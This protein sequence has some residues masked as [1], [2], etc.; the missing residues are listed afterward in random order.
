M[1]KNYKINEYG[2]TGPSTPKVFVVKEDGTYRET[3]IKLLSRIPNLTYDMGGG[4]TNYYPEKNIVIVDNIPV[5]EFAADPGDI[6]GGKVY[7]EYNLNIPISLPKANKIIV[8]QV[9]YH[10]DNVKNFS[11][12]LNNSLNKGG[13][14]NFWT[15]LEDAEED[16]LFLQYM[17]EYGF[18]ASNEEDRG[19]ENIILKK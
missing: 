8:S 3:S 15:D 18:S 5:K 14:I 19:W 16:T 4:E 13:E 12:T 7:V 10:L 9:V 2:N 11:Q 6:E 17:K 1:D